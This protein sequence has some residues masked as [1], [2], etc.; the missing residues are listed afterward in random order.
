MRLR[1]PLTVLL[2]TVLASA[3]SCAARDARELEQSRISDIDWAFDGFE[4]PL[5]SA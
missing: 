4:Y 3:G 2:F 1:N 5:D